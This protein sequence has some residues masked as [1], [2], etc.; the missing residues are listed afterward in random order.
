MKIYYIL[1]AALMLTACKGKKTSFDASG[2]FEADETIVSAEAAGVLKTFT[3]EEGQSLKAGDITGYVD[4]LQLYLRKKQ[5]ETQIRAVLAQKPDIG[6][7][8]AALQTQLK[9]AERESL[10]VSR[11]VKAE[12]ATQKQLDDISAQTDLIRTQIHAQQ[13]ALGITT[14][15]INQ[16][17]APLQVQIEQLNDQL[18]KCRVIN[19]VNGMVLTRY[20]AASEMVNPGK[21]LY[22]IA[23][24]SQL[25]LRAYITGDQLPQIKLNQ[26]VKVMTDGPDG[27]YKE[28]TGVIQW[29]SDKAEFTPK[30]IQ[31][32]DERANLVYAV[33]IKVK[34]DGYLK[35]G[36]YGEVNF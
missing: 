2:A 13:S 9:T 31:T 16:Q 35:I 17:T 34:N 28:Y 1:L 23:D 8:L 29:I 24:L 22:K 4:S 20:T 6:V 14:E 21:P 5:L 32:K 7:Q 26:Q 25:I 33:K 30:T 12:A 27:K 3:V 10:R 18:A 19:P 36:M 11:L 15:S